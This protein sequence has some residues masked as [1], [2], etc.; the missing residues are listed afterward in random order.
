MRLTITTSIKLALVCTGVVF[1]YYNFPH[2]WLLHRALP[3]ALALALGALV[4]ARLRGGSNPGRGRRLLRSPVNPAFFWFAPLFCLLLWGRLGLEAPAP[5]PPALWYSL[6]RERPVYDESLLVVGRVR[7]RVA[8]K[9]YLMDL[10]IEAV[11]KKVRVLR[12][13]PARKKYEGKRARRVRFDRR[14]DKRRRGESE[15]RVS[16]NDRRSYK[17]KKYKRTR[18]TPRRR[19]KRKYYRR[20]WGPARPVAAEAGR[21]FPALVRINEQGWYPGCRLDLRVYG[22]GVA[23]PWRSDGQDAGFAAYVRRKGAHTY[24]RL[25]RRYHVRAAQCDRPPPLRFRARRLLD[26]VLERTAAGAAERGVA[27]GLLLGSAGFLHGSTKRAARELGILHVFAA[28]GLHLGIFFACFA[29]PL[30]RWLGARHPLTMTA[31][32]PFCLAYLWLLDF[33]VSLTRAF[34]FVSLYALQTLVPVYMSRLDRLAN[35]ALGALLIAPREFCSLSGALSF[36]AVSAILYCM[37]VLQNELWRARRPWTSWLT[38]QLSLSTAAGLGTAPVLLGVFGAYSYGAQVANLIAVPLVGLLLPLLYLLVG[39][40]LAGLPDL[41]L[42][43]L[44]WLVATGLRAFV[45]LAEG[46]GPVALYREYDSLWA[47]PLLACIFLGVA[48]AGLGWR[49]SRSD[50]QGGAATTGGRTLRAWLRALAFVAVLALGPL[51]YCAEVLPTLL[52]VLDALR[53][54]PEL[55]STLAELGRAIFMLVK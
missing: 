23:R 12:R 22:R 18:S 13:K 26:G 8:P 33:P 46:P 51:G 14:A 15:R 39:L 49:A 42:G 37:P 1:F 25:S 27:R 19:G 7:S 24:L 6:S 45:R 29:L 28:S 48:L 50:R 4:L 53:S 5:E 40:D 21:T 43:P 44:R 47:P 30:G 38:G 16:G 17:A 52:R 34:V 32:L 3:V 9:T 41:L 2:D 55:L 10:R 35:T 20:R 54:R 11:Q 36:G 31:P